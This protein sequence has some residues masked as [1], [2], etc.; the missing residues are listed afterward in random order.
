MNDHDPILAKVRKLLALAEDPAATAHEAEAC[1][2]KA[3]QLIADYGIDRALLA[4]A[5]PRTDPVGDRVV[6][7]DAPYAADK[8]DLL[9]TV[10][11][12]L[13][14]TAVQRS[15]RGAGP[16]EL[17][18]HLFGHTSD[19]ERA[20]LLW[21]SLLLQSA[22]ALARTPVPLH[23]HKAAF[24]RSW[25]AGFRMAVGRRLVDAEAR[26][27][28][29]AA[30]RFAASG[31][32]GALVLADRS[33]EVVHAMETAYPDVRTARGRSLSGSGTGDGWAA[34]QRADLGATRVGGGR[35]ALHGS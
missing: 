15:R 14:C 24:R 35:R 31:T 26:A 20:E 29:H 25:L 34:G 23:E 28:Q 19:L 10:A 12:S 5:D 8:L 4:Q 2:A 22:H 1:T 11:T 32:S 6:D 7:V 13:R 9:A 21:T 33:A 17:S 27:Q 30:P 18:L 3:T 16:T